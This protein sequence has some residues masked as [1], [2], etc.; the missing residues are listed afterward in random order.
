M[1]RILTLIAIGTIGLTACATDATPK[2]DGSP[3]ANPGAKTYQDNNGNQSSLGSYTTADARNAW[4]AMSTTEKNQACA[5]RANV[6]IIS[7]LTAAG[8]PLADAKVTDAFFGTV[9]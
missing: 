3:N 8:Y 4:N 7:H 6:D 9:C 1:K 5:L 2:G